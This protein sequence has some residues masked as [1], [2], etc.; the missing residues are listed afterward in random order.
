MNRKTTLLS[1]LAL[2]LTLALA[3]APAQAST[4][5]VD[6]SHSGVDFGVRH[7]VSQVGGSFNDFGGTVVMDEADLGKSSVEFWIDAASIDTRNEN[8]DGHLRSEDFFHV[9]KYPRI[10]FVSENIAKTGDN[11]FD[12]TGT[13]TM[14]G[15]AKTVTLPV[16]FLGT[17][18][19]NRG[20]ARA[21]FSTSTVL[22]RKD[23]DIVWNQALDHGG[24][25][26]GD[27]VTVSV[28]LE[29]TEKKEATAA[30]SE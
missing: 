16:T 14:R 23:Y 15:V 26:L 25:V 12:V 20:N 13:L 6:Q 17:M 3:A 8:R 24:F 2:A 9:E 22:D 10:T 27:D 11:R 7:Y 30:G 19:D 4:W 28:N 21:G 1:T 5:V 29:M 18:P